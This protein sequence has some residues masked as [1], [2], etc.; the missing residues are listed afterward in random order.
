MFFSDFTGPLASGL[1]NR[2]SERTVIMM[3]GLVLAV[4]MIL[5]GLAPNIYYTF[6]SFGILGGIA[7]FD[8][9]PYMIF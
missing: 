1:S 5:T 8:N 2:F 4:S 9:D 7:Y 3:S 6:L